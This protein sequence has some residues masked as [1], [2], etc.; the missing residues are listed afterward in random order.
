MALTDGIDLSSIGMLFG[1]ATGPCIADPVT[2]INGDG[3]EIPAPTID[4]ATG[5]CIAEPNIIINGTC[6]AV[7]FPSFGLG[8]Y[9]T[10]ISDIRTINGSGA[11]L[12]V[13]ARPDVPGD[14]GKVIDIGYFI[15]FIG[16]PR[17]I[18]AGSFVQFTPDVKGVFISRCRW[19]FGDGTT[20]T[21]F[22]PLHAY[23]RTG[24]YTVKFEAW[25]VDEEYSSIE[26]IAYIVVSRT[27]RHYKALRKITR[28]VY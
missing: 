26:K 1:G 8:E 20:S 3:F 12:H 25:S 28:P 2:V 19:T 4:F 10:Q 9:F 21:L 23:M 27:L 6:L 7:P 5:S 14:T 17:S 24:R 22:Y 15:D 13:F 16:T 11:V 18:E